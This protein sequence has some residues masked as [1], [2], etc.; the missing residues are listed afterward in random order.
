MTTYWGATKSTLHTWALSPE[1]TYILPVVPHV[2]HRTSLD[3]VL[4]SHLVTPTWQ[5]LQLQT[6]WR[7]HEVMQ[8]LLG[9]LVDCPKSLDPILCNTFGKNNT[10]DT[11]FKSIAASYLVRNKSGP[12]GFPC[13]F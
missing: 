12:H 6:R 11:N 1:Y 3:L 2:C 5:L 9:V 10:T 13:R 4:F 8:A 7:L